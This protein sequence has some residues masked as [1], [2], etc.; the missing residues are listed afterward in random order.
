MCEIYHL[1]RDKLT[2][3]ETEAQMREIAALLDSK[4]ADAI[5]P[6]K[7]ETLLWEYSRKLQSVTGAFVP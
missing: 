4:Q 5:P 7:F 3:A 6:A 2:A 1:I